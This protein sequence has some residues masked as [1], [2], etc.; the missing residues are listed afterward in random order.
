MENTR[1][2]GAEKKGGGGGVGVGISTCSFPARACHLR[3]VG[4]DLTAELGR[5]LKGV[6]G[7]TWVCLPGDMN[8]TADFGENRGGGGGGGGEGGGGRVVGR[9]RG[10]GAVGDVRLNTSTFQT[11]TCHL[12]LEC[13][14]Q[15][16][17]RSCIFRLWCM[18]LFLD[19]IV[20]GFCRHFGFLIFFVG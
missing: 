8:L 1:H 16:L 9:W 13:R 15:I 18:W 14:V 6:G 3:S 7:V 4:S 10:R 2:R 12:L 11:S 5:K 17:V 20:G 19:L